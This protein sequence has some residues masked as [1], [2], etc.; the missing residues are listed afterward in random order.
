M[1]RDS[2]G[3]KI[4]KGDTVRFRGQEYTIRMFGPKRLGGPR[5][6]Y[7]TAVC[8]TSEPANEWTVDLCQAM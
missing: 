2:T 5:E 3:K 6:I 4:V 1:P 7:F 8:H